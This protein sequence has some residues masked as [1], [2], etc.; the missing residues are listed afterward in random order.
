MTTQRGE[1]W[2]DLIEIRGA[3]RGP[4]GSRERRFT[5]VVT[6]SARPEVRVGTEVRVSYDGPGRRTTGAEQHGTY[7]LEAGDRAWPLMR[8]TCHDTGLVGQ[9]GNDD[10]APA[11]WQAVVLPG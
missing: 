7:T 3:W 10:T 6:A 8:F 2:A 4:A 11:T 9:E 5:G 1:T